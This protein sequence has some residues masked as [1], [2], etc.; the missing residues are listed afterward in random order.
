MINYKSYAYAFKNSRAKKTPYWVKIANEINSVY[1]SDISPTQAEVK[2]KHMLVKYRR[3]KDAP[4]SLSW[5]LFNEM[6]E[7]LDG[8]PSSSRAIKDPEE[9]LVTSIALSIASSEDEPPKKKLKHLSTSDL[10]SYLKVA[11]GE[12]KREREKNMQD[13]RQMHRERQ[14]LMVKFLNVFESWK[15]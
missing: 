1:D 3:L 4:E 13:I 6:D 8:Q 10:I 14:E 12:D 5:H 11:R 2:W 9:T 15:D 7:V